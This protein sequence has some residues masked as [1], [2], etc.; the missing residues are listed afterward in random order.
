MKISITLFCILSIM[1]NVSCKKEIAKEGFVNVDG[2]KIWYKIVGEGDGVPLLILHGG[3]GSR[4]CAMIPGFSLLAKDR[5]IIFYDQLGSGNSDR[6]T[7]TTLW[8]TERFV[9]EIDYLRS[10]LELDNLHILG[11]SCGSTFLIEYMITKKPK[12]VKSVIFSS[13]HISSA[14]WMADAKILLS[15]LPVSIQDTIA[16]YES[17]KN[18]IHPQY[19]AATDSFNLRHLSLKGYPNVPD[20]KC[21]NEPGF[22]SQ[23]YNYMWG[24]TEFNITGTLKDFDRTAD[25]DKITEPILFMTGEYDEARPESMYKFQKLSNNASV[26]IID[27]AAHMTMIDQPEKV[28]K[29]IGR[30]LKNVENNQ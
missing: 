16:K 6:P 5:P 4:S 14:D 15:Q 30:F 25:L 18:Y 21:D 3:P 28:E 1:I 12:G 17:L 9:N 29:A 20:N 11:H 24:P 8:K 13:P 22:N 2:G 26:E 7:D 10:D 19:L 23:V 27:D